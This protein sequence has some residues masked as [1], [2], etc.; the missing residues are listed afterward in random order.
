MAKHNPNAKDVE[1]CEPCLDIVTDP[2]IKNRIAAFITADRE[3][4]NEIL[5][6][7]R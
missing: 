6:R 4:F 5:G 1:D 3:H 7:N 2:S